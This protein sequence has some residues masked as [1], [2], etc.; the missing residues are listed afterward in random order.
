MAHGG[1]PRSVC[2]SWLS[3]RPLEG[4]RG[5]RGPALEGVRGHC[6]GDS[7]SHEAGG[8]E[9]ITSARWRETQT[10]DTRVCPQGPPCPLP[11]LSPPAGNP[12][13]LATR[14]GRALLL[15]CR[16]KAPE[17]PAGKAAGASVWPDPQVQ[18]R[19][20]GG[21]TKAS[22]AARATAWLLLARLTGALPC[23]AVCCGQGQ[24]PPRSWP[25][26]AS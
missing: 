15:E 21:R 18:T 14:S 6:P 5:H 19:W 24:P 20:P 7:S 16:A 1:L 12:G 2:R 25:P 10:P 17:T 8:A 13:H 26:I 4:P 11:S 23:R 22:P 9:E 3:P